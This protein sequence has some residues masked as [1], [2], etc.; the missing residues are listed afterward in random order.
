MSSELPKIQNINAET[1]KA[2]LEQ[3]G[4]G[5][6]VKIEFRP[7][8]GEDEYELAEMNGFTR[9]GASWWIC[10]ATYHELPSWPGGRGNWQQIVQKIPFGLFKDPVR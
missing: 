4:S 1:W 8:Q 10:E 6:F 2:I 3:L 5:N 9:N 7:P